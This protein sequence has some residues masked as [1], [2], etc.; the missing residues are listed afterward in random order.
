[1]AAPSRTVAVIQARTGS[2]RLPGKVLMPLGGRPMLSYQLDR[3]RGV[4]PFPIVVATSRLERDDPVATLAAGAGVDCVRGSES[5]VLAR[6]GAVLDAYAPETL[7]RLTGDCPLTDPALVLDVVAAHQ[8]RGDDY[9]SNVFPRTFPCGLDVEVVRAPALCIAIAEA[10]DPD[11]REHVMPF[12]Y[13]RPSRFQLGNVESGFD[14]GHARWVVDTAGD[15]AN[16]RRMVDH[17][18][19]R[20][21]FTWR[22]ALDAFPVTPLGRIGVTL[23]RAMA[24]DA[25]LLLELRNDPDAVRTSKTGRAVA[26][27][28]HR[29]WLAARLESPGTRLWIVQ[30][31]P[32]D[33]GQLRVD[34]DDG[35]GTVSISIA[36]DHRGRG[37]ARAALS[38]V[39]RALSG[40]MQI[41]RLHAD[42]HRDNVA[43]RRVFEGAG[44]TTLG[45]TG[46]FLGCEWLQ[47]TGANGR[48]QA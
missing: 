14:L 44:F 35:V 24:G 5:D 8:A 17:F 16:V 42:V 25:A 38:A 1:M 18:A 19:P 4:L 12:V 23:R 30:D 15:M 13:R 37:L 3:L 33:V 29:A 45:E 22:E 20:D 48:E 40:D 34:I 10:I 7:I 43:S 41:T 32:V 27:E 47:V 2:T 46:D 36:A 26:P 28:E 6:F 31:G 39:Q 11:E 9:T 21:D